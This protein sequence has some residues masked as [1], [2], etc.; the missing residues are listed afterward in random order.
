MKVTEELIQEHNLIQEVMA[1][2]VQIAQDIRDGHAD[3]LESMEE[4][5]HFLQKF[6]DQY[7]HGKEE[8]YLFP[9]LVNSGVAVENG[10]VGVMLKEHALGREYIAGMTESLEK[11]KAGRGANVA[12]ILVRN[13]ESYADLITAHIKK[14]NEVLFPMAQKVLHLN[15]QNKLETEVRAFEQSEEQAKV[16]QE[17]SKLPERLKK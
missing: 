17:Y 1:I 14:E 12:K 9:A 2:A 5:V 13:T 8:K 15:E 16:Y 6:A 3:K 11:L 10:P 7:H 4:I